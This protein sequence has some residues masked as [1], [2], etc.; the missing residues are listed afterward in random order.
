[1]IL[2]RGW[3]HVGGEH[4]TRHV[5]GQS[6]RNVLFSTSFTCRVMRNCCHLQIYVAGESHT[7]MHKK[8]CVLGTPFL[9]C[10]HFKHTA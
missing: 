10:D 7:L 8:E 3:A 4:E 6:P 1:M 5:S 9:G 2:G